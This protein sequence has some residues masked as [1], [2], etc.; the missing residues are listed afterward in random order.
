MDVVTEDMWR[1]W[2]AAFKVIQRY[3]KELEERAKLIEETDSLKRQNME[4]QTLLANY[5]ESEN[6]DALIYAP[7][8]T[9]DF[10]ND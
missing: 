10:Q 8:E 3:E 6:N 9:V 4:F 2:T 1:I 5:I 7:A